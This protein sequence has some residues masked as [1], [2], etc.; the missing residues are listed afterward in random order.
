MQRLG[1]VPRLQAALLSGEKHST[2]RYAEPDILPGPLAYH[3]E[4]DGSPVAVVEVTRVT[5]MR[6]SEA[7][8]FLGK[9]EEWPPPVMLAGMREHYPGIDLDDTVQVVEHGAPLR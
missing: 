9:A 6:L 2:I 5:K 3:C 8:E 1:I 7:A 4:A